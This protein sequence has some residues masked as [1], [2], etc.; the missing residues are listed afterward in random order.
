MQIYQI[1]WLYWTELLH[2]IEFK[3]KLGTEANPY[4]HNWLVA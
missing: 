3:I 4:N 2:W 1:H